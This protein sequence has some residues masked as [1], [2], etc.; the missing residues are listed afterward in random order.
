MSTSRQ[1]FVLV[2]EIRPPTALPIQFIHIYI[3]SKSGSGDTAAGD[4]TWF[5]WYHSR[6][7]YELWVYVCVLYPR[8]RVCGHLIPCTDQGF[9]WEHGYMQSSVHFSY[10]IQYTAWQLVIILYLLMSANRIRYWRGVVGNMGRLEGRRDGQQL[11]SKAMWLLLYRFNWRHL[12]KKLCV[13]EG[14]GER[15]QFVFAFI[16]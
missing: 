10:R 14:V 15:E 13:W 12:I 9:I 5:V 7:I 1:V 2:I 6:Y 11:S 8:G 4:W 16:W 3:V